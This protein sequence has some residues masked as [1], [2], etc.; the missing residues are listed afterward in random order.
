MPLT[1]PIFDSRTYRE[2]LNEALARMSRD[3]LPTSTSN[4]PGSATHCF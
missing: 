3:E 4:S 1:E 2:L